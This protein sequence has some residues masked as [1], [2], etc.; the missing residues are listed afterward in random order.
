MLLIY[1]FIN[2]IQIL[3]R[4]YLLQNILHFVVFR[5]FWQYGYVCFENILI[6]NTKKMLITNVLLTIK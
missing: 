2:E 5:E 4:L 3:Y 1:F 6:L